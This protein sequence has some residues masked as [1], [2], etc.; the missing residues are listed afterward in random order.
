[1]PTDRPA[2]CLLHTS[3]SVAP[4]A[5]I[6]SRRSH[7]IRPTPGRRIGFGR[8]KPIDSSRTEKRG[9]TALASGSAW[10]DLIQFVPGSRG[11]ALARTSSPPGNVLARVVRDHA[12]AAPD[13]FR[14][15]QLH[16]P[17]PVRRAPASAFS[18]RSWRRRRPR[19]LFLRK[20][21][22]CLVTRIRA[23]S[24]HPPP[25]ADGGRN[26]DGPR[27]RSDLLIACSWEKVLTGFG[28][29]RPTANHQ[30]GQQAWTWPPVLRE[31][32]VVD[33]VSL[34]AT[35]NRFTPFEQPIGTMASSQSGCA[36]SI[37]RDIPT[38]LSR[39]EAER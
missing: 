37:A 16:V 33:L 5:R 19:R 32:P 26:S 24:T 12:D 9:R 23:V 8:R 34:S 30:L 15:V 22:F 13:V 35:N 28:Y 29:R 3:A 6:G 1:M 14:Q 7:L 2:R 31:P 18:S 25:T 36:P 20:F 17:R 39:Q 27:Y 11:S 21:A 4:L 10:H 38:L